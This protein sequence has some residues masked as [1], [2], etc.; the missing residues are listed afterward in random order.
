MTRGSFADCFV[1]LNK[2]GAIVKG[3]A[4]SVNVHQA[5]TPEFI[6]LSFTQNIVSEKV[7]VLLKLLTLV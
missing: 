5:K 3:K 6:L 1:K 4:F 2:T 7:L